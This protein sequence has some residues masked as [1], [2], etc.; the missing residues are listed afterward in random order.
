MYRPILNQERAEFVDKTW[1]DGKVDFAVLNK[2]SLTEYVKWPEDPLPQIYQE[3][4]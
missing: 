4:Y 2:Y 1:P 3:V